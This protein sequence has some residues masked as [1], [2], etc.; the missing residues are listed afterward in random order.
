MAGIAPLGIAK[1][2]AARGKHLGRPPLSPWLIDEIETLAASSALNIREIHEKIGK[3]AS[4]GR[5][6]EITKRVRLGLKDAL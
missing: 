6:G 4:R 5:V 3:K 1:A 2:A